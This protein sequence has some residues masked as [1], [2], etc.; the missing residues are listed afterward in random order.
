MEVIV[1]S[2]N[3]VIFGFSFQLEDGKNDKKVY[4]KYYFIET[5]CMF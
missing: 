5:I 3:H 2:Y 4:I 1:G